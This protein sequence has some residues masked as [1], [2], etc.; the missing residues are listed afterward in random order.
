MFLGVGKFLHG[1][2]VFTAWV[3]TGHG[4]LKSSKVYCVHAESE[5]VGVQCDTMPATDV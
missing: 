2:E 3:N 5:F 4:D 1:L